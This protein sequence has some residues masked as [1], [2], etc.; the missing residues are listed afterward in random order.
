M[1]A[2]TI[3][4]FILALHAGLAILNVANITDVGLD[5]YV[6]TTSKSGIITAPPGTSDIAIQ[7]ADP[8]FFN[9]TVNGADV[10]G[11]SLVSKDDFISKFIE[12][13][14][15]FGTSFLKFMTMFSTIIFSIHTLCEPYF[16]NFN[17]W[18]LEAIVDTVFGV[19]LAQLISG[20]SFKT[21]E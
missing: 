3:V 13:I 20:R 11:S 18:V 9:N 21:M 10:K 17:A 16:G 5:I 6:D 1:R 7:G 2:W 19:S 8:H 15:G 4:L 12:S 14:V